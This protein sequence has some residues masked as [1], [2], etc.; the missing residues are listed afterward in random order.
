MVVD[1]FHMPAMINTIELGSCRCV[2]QP[3]GIFFSLITQ[4]P[5]LLL[6]LLTVYLEHLHQAHTLHTTMFS[7]DLWEVVV[8]ATCCRLETTVTLVVNAQRAY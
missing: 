6:G 1:C 2:V 7:D 5:G 8:I 3:S 4:L